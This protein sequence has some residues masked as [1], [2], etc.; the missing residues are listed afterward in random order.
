M[1][2]EVN[3]RKAHKYGYKQKRPRITFIQSDKKRN[4]ERRSR[5]RMPR[6]EGITAL[7][8]TSRRLPQRIKFRGCVGKRTWS[9]NRVFEYNISK[10]Q[11]EKKGEKRTNTY[12]SKKKKKQHYYAG[13]DENH[14]EIA[15]QSNDLEKRR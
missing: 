10:K 3:P 8:Q 6:R 11:S 9:R 2:D 14:S 1:N 7:F 13:G 15:A 5:S 12:L 4:A